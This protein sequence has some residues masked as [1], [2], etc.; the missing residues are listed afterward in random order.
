MFIECWVVSKVDKRLNVVVKRSR[1]IEGDME[2]LEEV[3]QPL[4]FICQG[5]KRVIFDFKVGARNGSFLFGFQ[6]NEIFSQKDTNANGGTSCSCEISPITIYK[7]RESRVNFSR[8]KK[9][10]YNARF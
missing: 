3:V 9:T 6:G 5:S 2:I 4:Y 8:I 1:V 7:T 10:F